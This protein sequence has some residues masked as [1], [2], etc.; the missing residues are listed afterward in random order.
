MAALWR[1]V[2]RDARIL[3]Q[4]ARI[5]TIR[6]SQLRVE[7]WGQV[8]MDVLWYTSHILVF[9]VLFLHT[10]SIAGWSREQIRVFLGFLFISD[11][12]M[13]MWLG[14]AWRFGRDLKDG[15]LDPVRV[16]PSSPI[17]QYFFRSFSLEACVNMSVGAGYLVFALSRL[18][19]EAS[20]MLVLRVALAVAVCFWCQVVLVILFSVLEFYFLNSDLGQFLRHFFMAAED[21]PLDIFTRRVRRFLLYLVP[22]GAMAHMP[23]A[24]AIGKVGPG[25]G[26]LYLGW[27]FLVGLAVFAV[28][29]ASFRRYE[30][31]MG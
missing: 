8:T 26:V 23:A 28:W 5:G 6:K 3:Y 9:E 4:F 2:R 24:I 21:R 29:R 22:V 13:M 19:L 25:F 14:Q 10:P 17:I 12:F 1:R 30:S 16:R 11:A 18:G 20:P 15:A 27:L 31:A 7:F